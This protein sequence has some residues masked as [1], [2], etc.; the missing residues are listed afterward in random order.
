VAAVLELDER[1]AAWAAGF[2]IDGKDY[3]RR[4]RNATEVASQVGFCGA[5]GEVTNEQT[6]GQAVLSVP[7]KTLPETGPSCKREI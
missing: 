5:V 2:A 3:L 7:A 4:W 6:D 1:K